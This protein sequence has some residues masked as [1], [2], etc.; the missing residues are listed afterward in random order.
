[1]KGLV[2]FE[3]VLDMVCF[4]DNV[5]QKEGDKVGPANE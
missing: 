5:N 1:M 4:E 2:E 3:G